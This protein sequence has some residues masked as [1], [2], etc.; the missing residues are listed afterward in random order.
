MQQHRLL[1]AKHFKQPEGAAQHRQDRQQKD[2]R[3]VGVAANEARA[4]VHR[5]LARHAVHDRGARGGEHQVAEQ[6]Q[7]RA[8]AAV[9]RLEEQLMGSTRRQRGREGGV[10]LWEWR[11]RCC[12]GP[13]SA[14]LD[15]QRAAQHRHRNLKH[16]LLPVRH[17]HT[18]VHRAH[19][20]MHQVEACARA[21]AAGS[22]RVE[23]HA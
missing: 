19:Q 12:C 13:S 1:Q 6:H 18:L 22:I 8:P 15:R 9:V 3:R 10:V 20:Q 17:E 14:H 2:M 4:P 16:A 7:R 23:Q 5:L 11:K 21:T